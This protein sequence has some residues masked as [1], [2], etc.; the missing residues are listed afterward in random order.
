[1][2]KEFKSEKN[3]NDGIFP[4]SPIIWKPLRSYNFFYIRMQKKNQWNVLNKMKNLADPLF[5]IWNQLFVKLLLSN[6]VKMQD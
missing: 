4:A 5:R 1:M 6:L 3:Q 2:D